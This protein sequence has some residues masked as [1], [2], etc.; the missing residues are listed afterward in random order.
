MFRL[1]GLYLLCVTLIWFL[2]PRTII[3]VVP[4]VFDVVLVIVQ[5][6]GFW[7]FTLRLLLS[8]TFG[9]YFAFFK[10][11]KLYGTIILRRFYIISGILIGILFLIPFGEVLVQK[12]I[13]KASQVYLSSLAK[14]WVTFPIQILVVGLTLKFVFKEN[15]IRWFW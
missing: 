15:R 3:F 1:F 5:T 8:F 2:F 7:Q 12:V 14:L 13:S 6:N 9:Y 4:N 10:I 11:K